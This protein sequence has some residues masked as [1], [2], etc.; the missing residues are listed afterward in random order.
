[1]IFS[2]LEGFD[3]NVIQQPG[4]ESKN[5]CLAQRIPKVFRM[6]EAS[7]GPEQPNEGAHYAPAND[8]EKQ[9]NLLKFYEM[10]EEA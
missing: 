6:Q 5:D 2:Q 3:A 4:A 10:D 7:R 8:D 9:F 1:M